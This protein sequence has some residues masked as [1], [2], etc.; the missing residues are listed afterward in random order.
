MRR[1]APALPET[2]A[3]S[4]GASVMLEVG[5]DR[6]ALVLYAPSS[7]TGAEVEIRH[8]PV[9]WDGTH[10][11]IRARHLA[12]RVLHAGVFGSLPAGTYEVR[13]TDEGRAG[14]PLTVTVAAARVTEVA[15]APGPDT[16]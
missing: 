9:P 11:A 4:S 3:P 7:L 8:P 2:L 10:T 15:I 5:P 1:S 14:P 6:G 12:G 13:L 16:V